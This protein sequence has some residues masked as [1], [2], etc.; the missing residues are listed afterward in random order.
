MGM[1]LR[2]HYVVVTTRAYV[3][4]AIDTGKNLSEASA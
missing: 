2:S 1:A 3:N 4:S